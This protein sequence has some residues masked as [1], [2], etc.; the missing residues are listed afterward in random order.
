ML[1][2]QLIVKLTSWSDWQGL[3]R[4]D[5]DKIVLALEAS[6]R[7]PAKVSRCS[8]HHALT[9]CMLDVFQFCLFFR[10]LMLPRATAAVQT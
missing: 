2:H 5:L 4:S 8:Q 9:V 1:C 6:F 10:V 3:L 7:A